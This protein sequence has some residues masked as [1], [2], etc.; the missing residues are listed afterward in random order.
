MG[1]TSGWV[2]KNVVLPLAPFVVGA[3]VRWAHLG[4]ASLEVVNPAELS[5]SVAMVCLLVMS[6]ASRLPNPHLRDA[7]G[8]IFGFGLV[9]MV[10]LFAG[11]VFL[12]V[13]L[14]S[15]LL[16]VYEHARAGGVGVGSF[17]PEAYDIYFATF[18]RLR[19]LILWVCAVVLPAAVVSNHRYQLAEL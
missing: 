12:E 6:S 19:N 9:I 11:V 2:A 16:R 7:I 17:S 18:E 8:S 14:Q 10:A 1:K 3:A 4:E 5:F 15:A 13:E